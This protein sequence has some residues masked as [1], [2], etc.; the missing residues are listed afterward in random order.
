MVITRVRMSG[1]TFLVIGAQKCGTTWLEAM[2]RQHPE[3]FVPVTKELHF[4]DKSYHYDRGLEWYEAHFSAGSEARARGEATPNYFWT[5]PDETEK[6]AGGRSNEQLPHRVAAH[7]PDVRLIVSLRNPVDRAISA[8]YHHIRQRRCSPST[9]LKQVSDRWGIVSMGHYD[10]HLARW[11]DAFPRERLLVLIYEEDIAQN[12][13]A[14]LR[15]LFEFIGVDPT[16]DPARQE[17]RVNRRRSDLHLRLNFYAP[18]LA[19]LLDAV[20]PAR[21]THARRWR[22]EVADD[23]RAALAAEFAPHNARL[24]QLLGRDLPW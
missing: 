21:I 19:T 4:F 20:L 18:P 22:I 23:E 2:L 3:V 12:K 5:T 15:R 7:Y 13:P 6:R 16:R 14:T 11:L 1:P 8:Y 10:V 17:R 9:P 24:S